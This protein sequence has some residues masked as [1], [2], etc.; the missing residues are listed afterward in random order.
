LPKAVDEQGIKCGIV[1]TEPSQETLDDTDADEPP[2]IDSNETMVNVEYVSESVGVGDTIVDAGMNSGVDTQPIATGFTLNVDLPSVE[3]KFMPK[4]DAT[5][6]DE[7]LEH[8]AD[9]RPISELSNSDKILL[10]RALVET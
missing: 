10:Q 9:D 1:L 8:S 6:G 4:Y 7:W 2:F 3:L 5:F